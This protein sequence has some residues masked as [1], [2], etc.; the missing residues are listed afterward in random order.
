VVDDEPN[1]FDVIEIFLFQSGY[2]LRYFSSGTDALACLA[3][4]Q[5]DVILLDVMMPD[6]DGIEVCRR[7]KA[8]PQWQHIPIIIVT[9][10]SSK[11]DLARCLAAGANDF[12]SKPVN[13]LELRARVQS[14]LRLKQQY[15]QLQNLL[16]QRELALR[17]REDMSNMVVHD[18]RN[19]LV[20]ILMACNILKM[21]GLSETQLPKIEQIERSGRELQGLIDTLLVMAKLEAGRVLLN[22]AEVDPY[23]L[24]QDV[25]RAF[26]E[27]AAYQQIELVSILPEPGKKVQLD[28]TLVRRVLDNLL[29]NAIKFSP[30]Q[31]QV[32]LAI[33]YPENTQVRIQV[34]DM[35]KGVDEDLRQSIFEKYEIGEVFHGVTQTGL[36]LAFCKI[37]VEAHGGRIDVISNHPKGA[38]F[39]VEF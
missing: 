13:R 21:R 32:T 33:D 23:D 15:D 28:P 10:L 12:V 17:L 24:G 6:L 26:E 30:P 29:A 27:I 25:I 16:E 5:P 4:T 14:M 35:G 7:I 2:E 20:A 31:S 36:G 8:H 3:V 11:E 37:A 22:L 1:N 34:K 18:L 9:A 38:I 19:P 39:M